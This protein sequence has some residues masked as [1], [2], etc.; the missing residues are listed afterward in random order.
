MFKH[1]K[2]DKS[3]HEGLRKKHGR[4]TGIIDIA[5]G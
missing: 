4:M 2:L 1:R 5:G 3:I